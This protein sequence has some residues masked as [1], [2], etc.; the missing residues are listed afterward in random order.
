VDIHFFLTPLVEEAV[1]FSTCVLGFFVENQVAGA[2]WVYFCI[3]Y[4]IPLSNV[5]FHR[6]RKI[7]LKHKRPVLY[8]EILT[9]KID[10]GGI[11][12]P[13]FKLYY[14][15]IVTKTAWYPHRN[16]YCSFIPIIIYIEKNI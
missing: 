1:I 15:V 14:R 12:I 2:E 13:D 16:K 10:F 5:I 9:K 4:S 11:I 3:F 7:N 6:D 8:K